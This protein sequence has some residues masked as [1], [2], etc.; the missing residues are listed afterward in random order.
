MFNFSVHKVFL[1]CISDE[2]CIFGIPNII[3]VNGLI[4]TAFIV[5][6]IAVNE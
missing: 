6:I 4:E 3:Y 2:F 5:L 1:K